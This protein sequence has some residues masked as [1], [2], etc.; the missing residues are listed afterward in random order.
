MMN[1]RKRNKKGSY[2]VEAALCLPL[3][4]LVFTAIALTV[5]I[6]SQCED[7]VFRECKIIHTMDMKAPQ[8]LPDPRGDNYKVKGFR[9]LYF[10]GHTE[11]L[12]TLETV[13]DFKISDPIGI[14][15]RIEFRSR[16]RSKAFTGTTEHSGKLDVKDFQDR[17]PSEKV[18]V[19]PKYGIRFHK[20]GCRYVKQDF[21]GEEIKLEME[22]RDA[23]LKGYTPCLICG[24]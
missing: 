16:I 8:I 22:K 9:Y 3:F 2:I 15:G 21:A 19:F 17:S 14:A 23:E 1:I 20:S 6:I 5:N 11:D 12:I 10:D 18:V 13:S 4:I 7:I 24:G